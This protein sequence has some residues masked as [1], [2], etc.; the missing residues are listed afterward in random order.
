MYQLTLTKPER[1]AF[2]WVGYRYDTGDCV[3][4]LL[5][6]CLADG[7]EWDDAGDITFRIPEYVA[8][9]INEKSEMEDGLWPCFADELKA[10]MQALC[11]SIV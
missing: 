3:G 4:N 10:K 9:E 5:R 2:D 8:W 1:Y 7:H 11:D 6:Q